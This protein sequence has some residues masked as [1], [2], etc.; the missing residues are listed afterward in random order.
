MSIVIWNK[1]NLATYLTKGSKLY[2]EGRLQTRS[3]DDKDGVKRYV[4]E[5]VA[6]NLVLL[7]GLKAATPTATVEVGEK[8]PRAVRPRASPRM[9]TAIAHR[10]PKSRTSKMTGYHFDSFVSSIVPV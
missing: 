1:E 5:V 6:E 10:S 8:D 7:G 3:Y 4:T 2:V 9:V